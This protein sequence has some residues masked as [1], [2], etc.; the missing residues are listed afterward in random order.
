M[1]DPRWLDMAASLNSMCPSSCQNFTLKSGD[2][3]PKSLKCSLLTLSENDLTWEGDL[4]SLK[5]F[6][7][8]EL[9]INGRWSTPHGEI[10]NSEILNFNL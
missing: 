7:E 3:Y 6:V 8:A 2:N 4:E 10:S 1:I 9:Q 5:R